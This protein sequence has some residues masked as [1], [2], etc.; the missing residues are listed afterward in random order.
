M[1][2]ITLL[3]VEVPKSWASGGAV[4]LL[5]GFPVLVLHKAYTA[6]S[7]SS[8]RNAHNWGSRER[9]RRCPDPTPAGLFPGE[10]RALLFRPSASVAVQQPLPPTEQVHFAPPHPPGLEGVVHWEWAELGVNQSYT[11]TPNL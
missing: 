10:S 5:E 8:L 9:G 7:L 11:Q 2:G 4:L 6:A 3:L 1:A